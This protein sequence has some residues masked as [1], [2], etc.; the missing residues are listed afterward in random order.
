MVEVEIDD[1]IKKLKDKGAQ[2]YVNEL[3]AMISD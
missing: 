2:P 1:H 3:D